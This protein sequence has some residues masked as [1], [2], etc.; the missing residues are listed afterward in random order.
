[1]ETAVIQFVAQL[2]V[3][4]IVGGIFVV[5]GSIALAAALLTRTASLVPIG[6]IM[7]ITGLFEMGVGTKAREEDGPVTPWMTSGGAIMVAGGIAIVSPLLHSMVFTTLLGAALTFA[8]L[9]WLRAGF[10]LPGRFQSPIVIICGGVTGLIGLLV[11]S[12]WHGVNEN[13]LAIMLGCEIL[14]R[15]WSWMGFGVG[16]S[17]AMKKP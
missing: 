14:T 9:T 11:L 2:R 17:R 10:A 8:G 15:G 16:L 4:Y 7:A 12:R 1:M 6:I 3:L 5:L 13:L